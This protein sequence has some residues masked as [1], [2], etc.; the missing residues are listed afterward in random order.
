MAYNK[1]NGGVAMVT[2][3]GKQVDKGYSEQ[4]PSGSFGDGHLWAPPEPSPIKFD[5]SGLMRFLTLSVGC[6]ITAG[7]ADEQWKESRGGRVSTLDILKPGDIGAFLGAENT[8]GYAGHT[9]MVVS[10]N[11]NL[12]TGLLLNAYDT[13][14]GVCI[15]GFN[16]NQLTNGSNGLGVLGFYRPAASLPAAPVAII[17]KVFVKLATLIKS[18]ITVASSRVLADPAPIIVPHGGGDALVYV[19]ENMWQGIP[20]PTQLKRLVALNGIKAG[21]VPDT[22]WAKAKQVAW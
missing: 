22:W 7:N 16:R 13:A 12:R 19:T 21:T 8:P 2:L 9:G 18:P 10:Y 15:I 11:A 5:C 1:S 17:K 20:N 4:S 14:R 6:P 3:G